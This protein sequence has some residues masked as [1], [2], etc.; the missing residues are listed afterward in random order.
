MPSHFNEQWMNSKLHPTWSKWV[1]PVEGD[2][3]KAF[4]TFCKTKIDLTTMGASALK[5]HEKGKKH[6]DAENVLNP[7][8][9]VLTDFLVKSSASHSINPKPSSIPIPIELTS[10]SFLDEGGSL[11]LTDSDSIPPAGSESLSSF[12]KSTTTTHSQP[13]SSFA[14]STTTSVSEPLTSS[15]SNSTTVSESLSTFSTST[16]TTVSSKSQSSSGSSLQNFVL[17]DSVTQSEILWCFKLVKSNFSLRSSSDLNELFPK[18]FPDSLIAQQFALSTDKASY[19]IHFGIAPFVKQKLISLLQPCPFFVLLFDEAFNRISQNEQMDILVRFWHP[20]L[21]EVQ[22]RY[23]NSVFLGHTTAVDLL[24]G[25]KLGLEPLH[26]SRICQIS[27]DGPNVNWKLVEILK[28]EIQETPSDPS[29]IEIGSCGLHVLHGAFEGGLNATGWDLNKFLSNLYYLFKDSPARREDFTKLTDFHVF[30]KKLCATRWLENSPTLKRA[31]ECLPHIEKYVNKISPKPAII[32]FSNIS[33]AISD[34]LLKAKLEFIFSLGSVVEPFLTKYQSPSPLLPFL[35]DDLD[36][37]L[38]ALYRRILKPDVVSGAGLTSQ[39]LK[40]DLSASSKDFLP[41]N[42]I[43]IGF[44]AKSSLNSLKLPEEKKS[45]YL[46]ETRN[47]IVFII[48]KVIQRSPLAYAIVK[49]SSAL[50]PLIISKQK[51]VAISRFDSLL[52]NLHLKNHI[53]SIEADQCKTLFIKFCNDE[54]FSSSFREFNSQTTRLDHFYSRLLTSDPDYAPLFNVFKRVLILSHGNASV[55]SG[56]SSNENIL[57]EN[58]KTDS[59]ISHRHVYDYLKQFDNILQIPMT[60]ELLQNCR[61]A[62]SRY[63]DY[64]E[65]NR[66]KASE[67]STTNI[68]KRKIQDQIKELEGKKQKLS[69]SHEKETHSIDQE[70]RTL[71]FSQ[72]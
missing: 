46:T 39:L 71:K 6:S 3:K 32:S 49:A 5:S 1:R 67:S 72:L 26:L 59:L 4:C 44:G 17:K 18:M 63:R 50:C 23:F 70:I 36:Q 22:T 51:D 38:R 66:A 54:N 34:P 33:K 52:K 56:F 21:N 62:R 20:E 37:V 53:N 45:Q 8:Q 14:E 11:T 41:I 47:C 48:Q 12:S 13:F 64:L 35:F 55:E 30:P 28:P 19:Y 42:K 27:M 31:I 69:E 60:K 10:F 15:E 24:K 58:L 61:L 25:I 7:Q 2:N 43:D 9:P 68:N 57:V 65:Q 29:V 16:S 40:L